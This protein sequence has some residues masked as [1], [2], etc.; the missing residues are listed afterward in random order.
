MARGEKIVMTV[1]IL[2]ALGWIFSD[3]L[4]LGAFTIPG[5]TRIL[6]QPKWVNH[7]TIAIT[8]AVVLFVTPVNL[9]K[10]EFA[11]DW[12][13]ARR[14]P[15]EVLLLFGGG[16]AMADAFRSTGL[17]E[18]IGDKFTLLSGAPPLLVVLAVCTLLAFSG[19]VTS[20]TATASIMM[21]ILGGA[22]A[23]ALHMHPLLLMFP[24][25]MAISCGF[26]LPA[27]TPPNAIVFGA[28]R[29]TVPQMARAGFLVDLLGVFTATAVMYA[30]GLY[31]F[32]IDLG[33]VPEWAVPA[34]PAP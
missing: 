24:A 33:S 17:V 28:G 12:E 5:W 29:I 22:V 23:P 2:T 20:N 1:W 9:R 21:P 25:G 13:W 7:G 10:G 26:M 30:V 32:D 3:D 14:I 15:W 11:L 4:A 27:A 34:S 18:W 19:E 31:V 8:G 16:L 6:P